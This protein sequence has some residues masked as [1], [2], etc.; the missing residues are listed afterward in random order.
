MMI[1]YGLY[2]AVYTK[3]IDR[4]MRIAKVLEAGT[5]AINSTSPDTAYGE[6]TV[7]G[8]RVDKVE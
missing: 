8:C 2:A 1:E 7:M 6:L 5:V 3:D 4:A